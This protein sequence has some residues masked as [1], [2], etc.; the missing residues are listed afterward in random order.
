MA[1]SISSALQSGILN[2]QDNQIMELDSSTMV[3]S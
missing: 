1:N 3:P 2:L